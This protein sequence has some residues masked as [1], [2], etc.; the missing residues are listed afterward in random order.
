[1]TLM[2]NPVE[3][4]VLEA[5]PLYLTREELVHQL[6]TLTDAETVERTIAFLRG[7][8]LL[9]A[10][11]TSDRAGGETTYHTTERGRRILR[12][13]QRRRAEDIFARVGLHLV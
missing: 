8:R 9:E 11:A 6:A 4:A 7:R 5:C 1:M 3:Q 12:A 13:Q 2:L 10:L